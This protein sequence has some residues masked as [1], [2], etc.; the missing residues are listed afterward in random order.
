MYRPLNILA[1]L[2]LA[3]LPLALSAQFGVVQNVAKDTGDKGSLA[4]TDVNSDGFLDLIAGGSRAI[5]WTP[6]DAGK[7]FL[8]PKIILE[9]G[10]ILSMGDLDGDGDPDLA[11]IRKQENDLAWYRNDGQGGFSFVKSWAPGRYFC[12]IELMDMDGDGDLDV[13]AMDTWNSHEILLFK[14]SNGAGTLL[15]EQLIA[16]SEDGLWMK[17]M[18]MDSDGDLDLAYN[19][20]SRTKWVANLNGL[21]TSWGAEQ[22]IINRLTGNAAM[23][24]LD[25]DG[26]KDL[27]ICANIPYSSPVWF[28]RTANGFAPY[29]RLF[30]NDTAAVKNYLCVGDPD[31]DGD[32]DVVGSSPN[33]LLFYRNNGAG[34][35]SRTLLEGKLEDIVGMDFGDVDLDGDDDLIAANRTPGKVVWYPNAGNGQFSSPRCVSAEFRNVGDL[36]LSDLDMDGD[37]DVVGANENFDQFY[38][39]IKQLCWYENQGT[40]FPRQHIVAFDWGDFAKVQPADMDGDQDP[41]LLTMSRNPFRICWFENDGTGKFDS[42]HTIIS[43]TGSYFY[44]PGIL[45]NDLDLDG[46]LDLIVTYTYG[47]KLAWFK[48]LDGLGN[49]G[50][51]QTLVTSSEIYNAAVLDLNGD[52]A[53]DIVFG[54]GGFNNDFLQILYADSVG[55]YSNHQSIFGVMS[56]PLNLQTAD[57][58]GDSK[59]DLAVNGSGALWV[60]L[61]HTGFSKKILVNNFDYQGFHVAAADVDLDGDLDMLASHGTYI[62]TRPDSI[63][64]YENLD[65][66]GNFNPAAVVVDGLPLNASTEFAAGDL[67]GDG[68]PDVVFETGDPQ[69]NARIDWIKNEAAGS[70]TISGQCFWDFNANQTPDSGEPGLQYLS[71][72]LNPL[73][74]AVYTGLNGQFRFYVPPGVFELSFE[75]HSCQQMTTPATQ[76]VDTHLGSVDSVFFGVQYSADSSGLRSW[77]FSSPTRC[78][79]ETPFHLVLENTGCRSES[80]IVVLQLSSLA[81]YQAADPAPQT[82]TTDSLVWNFQDIPPDNR[83]TIKLILKIAG[84]SHVGDS[85]LMKVLSR[86]TAGGNLTVRNPFNY[87]S[88]ITCAY[89]PNDKQV[90]P[91]RGSEHRVFA[92]EELTYT[93]RFQNTG[94]DTASTVVLRDQLAPELDWSTLRPLASSHPFTAQLSETGLLEFFFD[95]IQLPDSNTN[96]AGSQGYVSFLIRLRDGVPLQTVIGNHAD[97]YFDQNPPILTNTVNVLRLDPVSAT[98]M[99]VSVHQSIVLYPNPFSESLDFQWQQSPENGACQIEFWDLT[100]RLIVSKPL[101]GGDAGRIIVQGLPSGVYVYRIVKE[102]DGKLVGTGKLVKI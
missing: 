53:P 88:V 48:N 9:G 46:D 92:G 55:H 93:I 5:Y 95:N 40:L 60:L 30:P 33:Q 97:I 77:L 80:G 29:V 89:D 56:H 85:V 84:A 66:L 94:T 36:A 82:I 27:V 44:P 69:E 79:R 8:A 16:T 99:P 81:T 41:D 3:F 22:E 25:G 78:N 75:P 59:A 32:I 26:L 67:D 86:T 74:K 70:R 43:A 14:N 15:N 58:D 21:G 28:K 38:P 71:V 102:M 52:A 49:F 20:F 64:W 13:V 54:T 19:N 68:D 24:D 45:P 72:H 47:S 23:A 100:Q 6:N 87:S 63:V 83:Q 4:Y 2:A 57:F 73:P 18:D 34:I 98:Q 62:D 17:L 11:C 1:A 61:S 50:P 37:L 39:A 7:G 91:A 76:I 12:C 51:Q 90:L 10:G 42:V 31:E 101:P 65:G 96:Q 35:F